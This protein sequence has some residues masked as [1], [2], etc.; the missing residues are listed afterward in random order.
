[1]RGNFKRD[2]SNN[3]LFFVLIFL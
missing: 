3:Y 1:L 2:S